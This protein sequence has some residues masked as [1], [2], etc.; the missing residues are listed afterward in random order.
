[1]IPI[2]IGDIPP[3]IIQGDP[4]SGLLTT[5][6]FFFALIA[7]RQLG[8]RRMRTRTQKQSQ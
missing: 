6:G 5:L 4:L 3:Y 8:L 1:M 2:I 7:G